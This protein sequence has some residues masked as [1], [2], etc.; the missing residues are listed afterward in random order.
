MDY[1]SEYISLPIYTIIPGILIML[2]IGALSRTDK[3]QEISKKSLIFLVA[4][5]C[6]W[7]AAELTWNLHEHVL[8]IDPYPSIA[9]FFY[10]SAPIFLFISLII[11]LHDSHKR[12]NK[13]HLIFA[14]LVSVS[15][16]IPISIMMLETNSE[17]DFFEI[18]IAL[19]YPIVD[20]ILIVPAIIAILSSF[21]IKNSFWFLILIGIV[22][23][24]IADNIYLILVM[25]DSYFDG[26]PLDI[27]WLI[28]YVIWSFAVYR[29]IQKSKTNQKTEFPNNTEQIKSKKLAKYGITLTLMLIISTTVVIL[30]ALN[31]FWS[32]EQSG[33]FMLFFSF[34][35]INITCGCSLVLYSFLI[36]NLLQR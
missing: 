13:K 31:Y 27:L 21:K 33:T 16:L 18:S 2:S 12:I 14:S 30:V 10:I 29:L 24:V 26:H 20:S 8:H 1:F 3:I 11:F 9:D 34:S 32:I 17:T 25:G 15:I 35:F 36:Q 28:S 23:F 22:G 19:I 7:F 6:L 5:F 4:A